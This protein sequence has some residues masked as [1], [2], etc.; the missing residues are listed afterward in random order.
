MGARGPEVAEL[1]VG[2]ASRRPLGAIRRRPTFPTLLALLAVAG[3]PAA[4]AAEERSVEGVGAVA[5]SGGEGARTRAPR[6][7]ALRAAIAEAVR[8]VALEMVPD[9]DAE[10][11]EE[12][13]DRALAPDPGQFASRFR[14]VEDRGEGPALLLEDP[15][16]EK[17]Y[18]VVVQAQVDVGRVRER[19]ARAGLL[20]APA[21]EVP[22]GRVRVVIEDL[23][24]YAAYMAVRTLLEELGVR[25]AVP[26]EMERGRAVLEVESRMRPAELLESLVRSAPPELRV[27]PLAADA[28]SLT[29]RARFLEPLGGT[30]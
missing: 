12:A 30:P 17:E 10:R 28:A 27:Q 23:E 5:T 1:A 3:A 9:R 22:R 20:V 13:V 8:Q 6:E 16:V 21:E 19:L 26:V 25:L 18:V 11:A 15:G 29:L 4:A 24:G 14:I 7:A 2:M